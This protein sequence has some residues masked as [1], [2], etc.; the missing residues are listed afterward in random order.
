MLKCEMRLASRL[1]G[2]RLLF[3]YVYIYVSCQANRENILSAFSV[4]QA[5]RDTLSYIG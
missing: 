4:T 5:S 3:R 2:M 1:I